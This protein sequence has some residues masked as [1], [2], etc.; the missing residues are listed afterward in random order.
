MLAVVLLAGSRTCAG[1]LPSL[2]QGLRKA[3]PVVLRFA[4]ERGIAN[5]GVLKFRIKK[6]DGELTDNVGTL[7]LKLAERFEIALILTDDI[8]R[9]IGIVHDASA[10]AATIP[11]ASHLTSDG[12]PKLFEAKYPLAWG[13]SRVTP[14]AFVVGIAHIADDLKSMTVGIAVCD[15]TGEKPINVT[16]FDAQPSATTLVETGESFSVR[17]LFDGGQVEIKPEKFQ[18]QVT[19]AT[20]ATAASSRLKQEQHPLNDPAVPVAL[21]VRF[22]GEL[23]PFQFAAGEL[24]IRE[25]QEKQSVTFTLLRRDERDKRRYACVLRVNGENT[26]F[27]QRQNDFDCKKWILE[28]GR[29]PLVVRGFQKTD[30]LVSEFRILSKAES[31]AKEMDYGADVGTISLTVFSEAGPTTPKPPVI[32]LADDEADDALIISRGL[33]LQSKPKSL[34]AL[35]SQLALTSQTRGLIDEGVIGEGKTVTVK[36]VADPRPIMSATLRYYRP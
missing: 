3:A 12:R 33:F 11:G 5:L 24:R 29:S 16:Q 8:H 22:D 26:L 36:F 35:K 23:V 30:D 27:R 32:D 6:G 10:V 28:P 20:F 15:K 7:N 31:K 34:D 9:P 25:P 17:G 21:E 2:E 4:K 18:A 13:D 1:D 14:D 19:A